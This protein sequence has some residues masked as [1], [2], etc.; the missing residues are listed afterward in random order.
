MIAVRTVSKTTNL[1]T[2]RFIGLLKCGFAACVGA[3]V[4]LSQPALGQ[5]PSADSF[6]P[7]ADGDVN[8]LAV[9]MDGKIL[10]GGSFTFL[11]GSARNTIGRLN[12]DGT[13]DSAFNPGAANV[14]NSLAVQA[15]GKILVGGNFSTLGGQPRNCIGRLNADGTLDTAFNP[16]AEGPVESL[17]V[18]ADG[19]ILVGGYFSFLVGGHPRNSIWRLNADGTLDTAFNPG[20]D[21]WVDSLALQADGKILVGGLFSTLGGQTRNCIGRLNA[22]GT[23]DTAFNPGAD[24][25]VDSLAVQA[26]GKILVGGEFSTL[27]GQPRN[28]IG[29]LNADGSLDSAFNPG[30]DSWVESLA[31]Q[32]DGK[33]LVGGNF[34]TLGGQARN[35]I[36]RLN[37]DGTLDSAFNPGAD[38]TV[39]SLA[40]QADGKILVGGDFHTLGGQARSYLGRLNNTEPAT[41]S[42]SFDASTITWMRGGASPEVWRTTF[43]ATTNGA[44]WIA[45]GGGSRISGGW[46]VAAPSVP[47]ASTLRVRGFVSG[48]GNNGSQWFVE[49]VYGRPVFVFQPA[50][51]TNNAGST[52]TMGS[53]ALGSEPIDFQWLKN[54]TALA[55]GGNIAG[56]STAVVTL[57]N[58]SGSDAGGYSVVV[59]NAFGS[60][61]SLLAT[62]TVV[63]PVIVV[64]PA[65]QRRDAGQGAAFSVTAVGTRPFGYQWERDGLA[66]AGATGPSLTLTNLQAGEAGSYSVVVSNQYGSAT[67]A[68]AL[69]TVNLATLDTE[70]NA[71]ANGEVDCLVAQ[72]DGKILVG[73]ATLTLGGQTRNSIG[74]LNADGTLDSGFSPQT[75]GSLYSLAVQEDGLVLVGGA[76][77]AVAGQPRYCIGRLNADGTLDAGFNP[78]ADDDVTQLAVAADGKIVV[79]GRFSVLGWQEHLRVGLLNPDGTVDSGFDAAAYGSGPDADVTA[80]A[81]QPDGKILLAGWFQNGNA[82]YLARLS[83]DGLP[84]SS[85]DPWVEGEVDCLAMQAD[86]KILVGGS[87]MMLGGQVACNWLGRLNADGTLDSTF[88]PGLAGDNASVYSL[89]LQVDG[90]IL[91]GGRFSGLHGQPRN[92]IARLNPDGTLDSNFAPDADSGVSSLALQGDGKILV[93]GSFATL[94]SQPCS[95]LGR[96]NNTEPATQSLSFDASTITWLRGGASPEV[97]R[98]TF[99]FSTDGAAWTRLGAGTRIPAGWQLKGVSPPSNSGAVRARGYVVGGQYGASSWFVE[100]DI[101]ITNAVV[102]NTPPAILVKDSSFGFNSNRFAFNLTGSPGQVVIVEASTNL[103]NWTS[104]ATNTIGAAPIYYTEPYSAQFR[105]RFYRLR[106]GP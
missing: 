72:A 46:Q 7:G 15:D 105:H 32:A 76:F 97:W 73:G 6:N 37:A 11:G 29:R 4:C 83:L 45:L 50:S 39:Y 38:G 100:S 87:G 62:L 34:Y 3:C 26:D 49:T 58:V 68:A 95:N 10:V 17:A 19:K 20:A 52:A 93:G 69:L 40:V 75:D 33:I 56:A 82:N 71:G 80:L 2:G 104:T 74:R 57:T 16:G 92:N 90:N 9:Q 13:L 53:A 48:G 106:V 1:R 101:Q 65:G 59:S 18:Q 42:L 14:V 96:L 67:S 51:Q 81:L 31:L 99:D 103:L 63:D 25:E 102:V 30:A 60:L 12:A 44:D 23:L 55:D 22:D 5:S 35:S 28:Y 91:V 43:E 94:D 8:S 41:Q 27:G 66:L 98:T 64:Q 70:F 77:T 21:N 89:A 36:G 61:T 54:G 86:G 88:K 84:D 78:G 79:A 85:F 47:P 24:L